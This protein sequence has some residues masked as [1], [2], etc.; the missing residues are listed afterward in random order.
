MLVSCSF[1]VPVPPI[2]VKSQQRLESIL[3]YLPIPPALC[4]ALTFST[5]PND[6]IINPEHCSTIVYKGHSSTSSSKPDY[7]YKSSHS[8]YYYSTNATAAKSGTLVKSSSLDSSATL[9]SSSSTALQ[10]Y[11]DPCEHPSTTT[12]IKISLNPKATFRFLRLRFFRKQNEGFRDDFYYRQH[13]SHGGVNNNSSYYYNLN[14]KN[15]VP[16]RATP[17]LFTFPFP[18]H[19][20]HFPST[21][22][23]T[24][25]FDDW[26]KDAPLLT[27]NEQEGRFEAEILVDLEKLPE[28][29]QEE[30]DNSISGVAATTAENDAAGGE[31]P[32]G[33]KLKRKLIYKFVLDGE[34]WVTDAGQSLERDYEGNLNNIRFLENVPGFEKQ[35]KQTE[36]EVAC[37]SA[38]DIM[39]ALEVKEIPAIVVGQ[40]MMRDDAFDADTSPPGETTTT[41]ANSIAETT[42]GKMTKKRLPSTSMISIEAEDDKRERDGDYGVAI[43]RGEPM[44]VSTTAMTSLTFFG[45]HRSAAIER[46]MRM[47]TNSVD[48]MIYDNDHS[49]SDTAAPSITSCD[50][51]DSDSNSNDNSLPHSET[52]VSYNSPPLSAGSSSK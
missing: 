6:D 18:S 20:E 31:L 7:Y 3:P 19:D 25:S 27:K 36:Y 44:T 43:L 38:E 47:T 42:V 5:E 11:A 14:N 12:C 32:P 50:L 17:V 16:P 8:N 40:S 9:A 1:F 46:S 28:V 21:V 51:S 41:T 39:R 35:T 48:S 45:D 30:N 15:G 13:P 24:G 22:Q 52:V 34:Q 2:V 23:V 4:S 29:Y 26:Q 10:R 49:D 33:A 37:G